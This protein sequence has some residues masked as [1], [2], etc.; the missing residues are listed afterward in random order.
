VGGRK[1]PSVRSE[2]SRLSVYSHA[3][4]TRSTRTIGHNR[5]AMGHF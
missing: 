3:S 2:G 1:S 4:T 5:S